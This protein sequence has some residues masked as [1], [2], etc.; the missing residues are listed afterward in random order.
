MDQK[1]L[2]YWATSAVAG[3]PDLESN[4]AL[5]HG[6]FRINYFLGFFFPE[7][8]QL[9]SS[10]QHFRLL[11]KILGHRPSSLSPQFSLS[12]PVRSETDCSLPSASAQSSQI[13]ASLEIRGAVVWPAGS[14]RNC[15]PA[16]TDKP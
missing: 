5:F 4:I 8:I 16:E 9:S 15:P 13:R 6:S 14:S 11:A 10:R 2:A 7:F 12:S 3:R 1:Y